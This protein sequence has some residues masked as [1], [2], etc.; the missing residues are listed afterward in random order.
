MKSGVFG[1]FLRPDGRV[2]PKLP[3]NRFFR[4]FGIISG[5]LVTRLKPGQRGSPLS[6]GKLDNPFGEDPRSGPCGFAPP[7]RTF[8]PCIPTL[9]SD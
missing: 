1:N 3:Q 7:R 4:H 6:P 2:A 9:A 5:P 8:V